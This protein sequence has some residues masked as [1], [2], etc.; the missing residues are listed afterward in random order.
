M[1]FSF[2]NIDFPKLL[3]NLQPV[4]EQAIV[5]RFLIRLF[6]VV[7]LLC[8]FLG[9]EAG[10]RPKVLTLEKATD[11]GQIKQ[12]D[13]YLRPLAEEPQSPVE[14]ALRSVP[15]SHRIANSC[16]TRLLPTHSGTNK[17]HGRWATNEVFKPFKISVLQLCSSLDGLC[18]VAAPPRLYYVIALRRLLC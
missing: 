17:H 10:V 8:D 6:L 2:N 9:S 5:N 4:I 7:T 16:P 15:S 1:I 18:T 11:E 12:N 14:I 13:G 3:L